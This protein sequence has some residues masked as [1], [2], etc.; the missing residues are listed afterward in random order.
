MEGRKH[1]ALWQ[2]HSKR[3]YQFQQFF[4]RM[5]LLRQPVACNILHTKCA[6]GYHFDFC[7]CAPGNRHTCTRKY[8]EEEIVNGKKD[9][10]QQNR[11]Q[12]DRQLNRACPKN[13]FESSK[14]VVCAGAWCTGTGHVLQTYCKCFSYETRLYR[15]RV[16]SREYFMK[17]SLIIYVLIHMFAL[18]YGLRS[19][20]HR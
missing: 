5:C 3:F 11:H 19:K 16:Q 8:S 9:I 17:P 1:I 6:M 20:I 4:T 15:Y 10:L 12:K 14:Y 7:V 13:E 2:C 18:E